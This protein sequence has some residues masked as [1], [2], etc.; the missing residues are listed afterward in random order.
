[1]IMDIIDWSGLLSGIVDIIFN[2]IFSIT[3]LVLT[4]INLLINNLLP[5]LE[6]ALD[7]V[8]YFFEEVSNVGKFVIS[9]TGFYQEI[10]DIIILLIVAIVS[11]PLAVHG[12]KTGLKWFNALKL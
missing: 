9:Y 6:D 4:P 8:G 2:F 11:I 1:M 3:D 12:I 7:W 10:I 5:S